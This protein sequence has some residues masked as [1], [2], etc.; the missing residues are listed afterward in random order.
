MFCTGARLYSATCATSCTP[1]FI[2]EGASGKKQGG[3]GNRVPL[4]SIN[5]S[6]RGRLG[7]IITGS[8]C[9]GS[10]NLV[11]V[12]FSASPFFFDAL[13]FVRTLLFIGALLFI[14]FIFATLHLISD[15]CS[16]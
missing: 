11:V 16:A 14:L 9:S 4:L 10:L 12:A 7:E 2:T 13:L 5:E 8:H 6:C 3:E 1:R 15:N